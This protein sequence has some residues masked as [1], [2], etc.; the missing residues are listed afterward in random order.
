MNAFLFPARKKQATAKQM[1]FMNKERTL[2][3]TR[4]Q[5]NWKNHGKYSR[6]IGMSKL[7][8]L[9]ES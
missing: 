5:R 9:E 6:L 2:W 3:N 7:R 4:E 8:L 1:V